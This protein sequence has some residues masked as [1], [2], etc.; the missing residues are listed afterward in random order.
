MSMR[1]AELT[2]RFPERSARDAARG[3]TDSERRNRALALREMMEH[4]AYSEDKAR[5]KGM[6]LVAGVTI[7]KG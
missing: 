6:E 4:Q 3:F 1:H 2:T 5:S 7:I